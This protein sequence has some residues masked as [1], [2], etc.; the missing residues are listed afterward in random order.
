M[1]NVISNI[2]YKQ[3]CASS[4]EDIQNIKEHTRKHKTFLRA[5]RHGDIEYGIKHGKQ[6]ELSNFIPLICAIISQIPFGAH[7]SRDQLL[8]AFQKRCKQDLF[9]SQSF[10][11]F[12]YSYLNEYYVQ[13]IWNEHPIYQNILH[14]DL[15]VK[16][17]TTRAQGNNDPITEEKINQVELR[18]ERQ[19]DIIRKLHDREQSSFIFT[20]TETQKSILQ[21]DKE[22]ECSINQMEYC[23]DNIIE[24]F[25]VFCI[26]KSND[27][28]IEI[29]IG[30]KVDISKHERFCDPIKG[31]PH[32]QS[33]QIE[34]IFSSKTKPLLLSLYNAQGQL[35]SKCIFKQGDDLRKDASILTMFRFF[36]D[37]WKEEECK[38]KNDLV[39]IHTYRCV[40]FCEDFGCIEYV[41]HCIPLTQI[42]QYDEQSNDDAFMDA[43]IA[44]A[45]GSYIGAFILGIRDR[46]SDNILI[47]KNGTLFHIDYG[48]ILGEKLSGLDASAFAI[49]S[50]LQNIMG[51]R[52][53]AFVACCVMAFKALRDHYHD[54]LKFARIAVTFVQWNKVE[55]F[56]RKQLG[57]MD[58]K[59]NES[60]IG[61][62]V[63]EII[64]KA[65]KNW[66]TK[67]KNKIHSFAVNVSSNS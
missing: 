21:Q 30:F 9:L 19:K 42:K 36:N 49:T 4:E 8:N 24:L 1:G 22:H 57:V 47:Q 58:V 50:D 33:I 17:Q 35:T 62:Y 46:H 27:H 37:I 40:P 60:E 29:K 65:P 45:A 54:I 7:G 39:H 51:H 41:D 20:L 11:C 6:N 44:S 31:R 10:H 34:S 53:D 56:L 59:K 48:Y 13:T 52:W 55:A 66:K 12:L 32:L 63:K 38:Y 5:I 25:E 67:M 23:G 14:N 43:L 15:Q 2:I 18:N 61:E 3:C 26:N 64:N 16:R 28:N